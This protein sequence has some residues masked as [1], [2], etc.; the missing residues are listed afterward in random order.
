MN[1]EKIE[2]G[3]I[4]KNYKEM[5]ELL[6]EKTKGGDSKKAQLKEWNRYF[7][8]SKDGN[9]FIIEEIY[10]EVKDK[11]NNHG[12]SRYNV[13][14]DVIQLLIL[15]LLGRE[16]GVMTIGKNKLQTLIGMTNYNFNTGRSKMEDLAKI[17][18]TSIYTVQDFYNTNE[19]NLK[20]AIEN[21]LRIL[22]DKRI[23]SYEITLKGKVSGSSHYR[24]LTDDEKDLV[25]LV[26]GRV[27]KQ[28]GYDRISD[29]R[30][31]SDWKGYKEKCLNLFKELTSL[32][33]YFDAYKLWVNKDFAEEE[34]IKLLESIV[35]SNE[36]FI[37]NKKSLN[38]I[39]IERNETNA[40]N[41]Q[42]KEKDFTNTY[43]KHRLSDDYVADIKR[44]S[45]LLLDIDCNKDLRIMLSTNKEK[46]MVDK[47]DQLME[48]LPF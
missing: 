20:S 37:E 46:S 15:N 2:V 3:M 24:D 40:L 39:V 29:V 26:E 18:E 42:K 13:Y 19:D 34:K 32:D 4:V 21:S 44:L 45:K 35:M 48:H 8:Y 17:L 6:G 7:R 22:N 36:E 5:C 38:N 33:Y 23:I 11:N 31:T 43:K 10:E 12:G 30:C 9:K 16:K 47:L 25:L 1:L 27:L 41:R 28:M 14:G